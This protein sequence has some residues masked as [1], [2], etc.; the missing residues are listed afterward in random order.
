MEEEEPAEH[1]S[2]EEAPPATSESNPA[3]A[4]SPAKEEEAEVKEEGSQSK[5]ENKPGEKG[6]LA[7][8]R[9][10]GDGQVRAGALEP[11]HPESTPVGLRFITFDKADILQGCLSLDNCLHE[12]TV[13]NPR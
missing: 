9:Q 6:D 11:T 1:Y 5:E 8:E 10:S 4:N 12:L 3:A 13:R 7:G 2:D